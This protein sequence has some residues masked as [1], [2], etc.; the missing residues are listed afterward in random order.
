MDR[1]RHR[2]RVNHSGNGSEH[3][4]SDVTPESSS[5]AAAA[6]GGPGESAGPDI[7]PQLEETREELERLSREAS[8][9]LELAKRKQA[10]F[11]NYRRRMERER[12]DKALRASERVVVEL[13]PAIDNLERAIAHAAEHEDEKTGETGEIGATG[14]GESELLRG[15]RLVHEQILEVLAREGVKLEDPAGEQFDPERHQAVMQREDPEAAEGTV[16]EVFNKGYVMH[17]RVLRPATV[18][19]AAAGSGPWTGEGAEER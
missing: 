12:S 16:L 13:M 8:E 10:E 14:G 15:V 19:V 11:E 6:S 3:D 7:D 4:D 17:D 5:G 2:I 1:K 9:N 18:V